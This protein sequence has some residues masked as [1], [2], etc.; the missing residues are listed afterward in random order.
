MLF[1]KVV[2]ENKEAGMIKLEITD[3]LL[4][5]ILAIIDTTWDSVL[6]VLVLK[7]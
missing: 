4:K 2:F 3:E 1:I 6:V 5:E 7:A